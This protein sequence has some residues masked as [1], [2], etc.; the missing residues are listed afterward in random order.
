MEE[1]V[2]EEWAR[3]PQEWINELVLKQESWVSYYNA[4]GGLLLIKMQFVD[5]IEVGACAMP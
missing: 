5:I 1:M 2:Q 4:T 3:V